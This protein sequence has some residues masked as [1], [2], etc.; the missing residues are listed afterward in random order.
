METRIVKEKNITS[1][2]YCGHI[3]V[4]DDDHSLLGM[5]R[6]VLSSDGHVVETADNVSDALRK[7]QESLYDVFLIDLVMPEMDGISLM[8]EA[9]KVQ[10]ESEL[11]IMTGFADIESAVRA[12]KEGA[13]NYITK[14]F[15]IEKLLIDIQK[16]LEKKYLQENI[17]TLKRQLDGEM[18][19]GEM[20]GSSPAMLRVFHLIRQVALTDCTVLIFGESGT[21][22]ELVAGEIH[23]RSPRKNGPFI[24]VSCGSLPPSLLESELFGHVRGAFTGASSTKIGLFEAAD[25]G[26]IFLDEVGTA[27]KQTQVGLLR[28][29]QNREIRKIG[30]TVNKKINVRV[31]AATNLDLKRAIECGEFREDLYYRLSSVSINLPPLRKRVEDIIPLANK[32]ISQYCRKHGRS[33]KTLSPKA[34]EFLTC[35]HWPGNIRELENVIENAVIVSEREIIR[36]KDLPSDV[37]SEEDAGAIKDV[38]TL[39]QA[40]EKHIRDALMLSGGNKLKASKML[41]IPRATLY[42]KM[43]RF[44]ID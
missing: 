41:N 32:F 31:I 20:I 6:D 1:V 28:V 42:R 35:Y 33:A 19:F 36:P 39:Q 27:N 10:P 30:S 25:G 29:L 21:G 38:L 12:I 37:A 24:A 43:Q 11:I 14:P 7:I 4:I 23:N 40:E 16:T 44:K 13:Y 18:R 2:K 22:K 9:M 26:T 5:I 3:L 8:K 17:D 34:M 15:Q